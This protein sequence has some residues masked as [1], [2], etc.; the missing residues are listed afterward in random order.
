LKQ[1][2]RV[3]E[4][5]N[6]SGYVLQ[7]ESKVWC[8]PNYRSIDYIDGDEVERRLAKVIHEATDLSVLSAELR[9]QCI[10]WPSVYHLSSSRANILRPFDTVLH[11]GMQVLEIGAG[12][13]AVTRYL[14]ETGA[15]VTALERSIR[16]AAIARARTRDLKNINVVADNFDGFESPIKFDMVTLIGVLEYANLFVHDQNPTL[17]VLKRVRDLLKVDGILILAI[18][19]QLGLKYF[20]GAPEDHL[21]RLMYGI[22][23]QYKP[24]EPQTFGQV[25][26]TGKLR[27]A[28]FSNVEVAL[29]FPDYKHPASILTEAA[30]RMERFDAAAFAWQSVRRDSQLPK[31]CNFSPELAWG[32]IFANKLGA[33]L[34][35]S[36]LLAA[37]PART[38][39]FNRRMLAFHYATDRVAAYCKET[40]FQLD[41]GNAVEVSYKRLASAGLDNPPGARLLFNCPQRSEYSLGSPLSW[42]FMKLITAD[43]WVIEDVGEFIKKYIAILKHFCEEAG[44]E[45]LEARV[46]YVLPGEFFDLIPQNIIINAA[47][48]AVTIDKEWTM[49]GGVELGYLI[50]RGLLWMSNS[51]SRFGVQSNSLPVTRRQFLVSAMSSAGLTVT[52]S[53]IA[54][55]FQQEVRVQNQ[56]IGIDTSHTI[57]AVLAHEL[58]TQHAGAALS[59]LEREVQRLEQ[60]MDRGQGSIAEIH[61]VVAQRDQSLSA[62]EQEI[63]DLRKTIARKAENGKALN[64]RVGELEQMLQERSSYLEMVLKSHSWMLTMPF[65]AVSWQARR[66]VRLSVRVA[67]A[68]GRIGRELYNGISADGLLRGMA[69]TVERVKRRI[70]GAPEQGRPMT[71][72]QVDWFGRIRHDPL[73]S[74]LAVCFNGA[75]HLPE[76]LESLAQ[77]SYRNYEVII[78]DNGSSDGSADIIRRYQSKFQ[79]MQLILADRNLGFAEGNNVALEHARGELLLLVNVDTRVTEDWMRELVEALRCDGAAAIAASKILFWTRFHDIE[80]VTT[81]PVELDLQVLEASLEYKKYFVRTGI[82]TANKL[83]RTDENH[84]LVI[85]VPVQDNPVTLKLAGV[86][87]AKAEG[88]VRASRTN[89]QWV[90][91]SAEPAFVEL[92]VSINAVREAGFIINNAGSSRGP[93]K[94]PQDRGFGQYDIGQFDSKGYVPYCCGCSVMVRRAAIVGR[95]LFVPEF[96]AYY[97]DSELSGWVVQRGM[98]VL[99]V[100]R[101][102]LFHKHS[103][104]SSEGSQLWNYLVERSRR[105]FCFDNDIERLAKDLEL[106]RAQAKCLEGTELQTILSEYDCALLRRL[107]AN[108]RML[109]RR[110]GVAIYNSYWNTRGGGESHALSL[111]RDLRHMGEIFLVSEHDFDIVALQQY[112]GIDLYYCRKLVVPRITPDFTEKFTLFI[113]A[114]Y[115]SNLQSRAAYS[116]YIVSFPHRDVNP[117]ILNSY[118]F[119]FNSEYTRKWARL[120]WGTEVAGEVVYP[121]RMLSGSTALSSRTREKIILSVG[122]FFPSDHSKNQLEIAR[123]FRRVVATCK[124]ARGWKLVLA[125]SLNRSSPECVAYFNEVQACLAGLSAEVLPDLERAKVDY[126]FGTACVYVHATGLLCDKKLEPEKFEHFGITVAEAANAGCLP[127]VLDVGGPYELLSSLGIGYSFSSFESLVDTLVK[128]IE[129]DPESLESDRDIV[130]KKA[131]EFL[132]SEG[133]RELPSLQ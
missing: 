89:R 18:E 126:L 65:R 84:R 26:L 54:L 52:S 86:E 71:T 88:E 41:Q 127:V 19:N 24:T 110:D 77:Q 120:L 5:L 17:A 122:R 100:P 101:S 29:P 133:T 64:R 105:I 46:D 130:R 98:K 107:R 111:A 115:R 68:A 69:P 87:G 14:G 76:F 13:G 34:S 114:T 81:N 74:V 49:L 72:V 48:E 11:G 112:F 83:V 99:Y 78:V 82:A 119:L 3:T 75:R 1:D 79:A 131:Q 103:A 58:S 2:K 62:K 28:G 109:P 16:R 53:D 39:I 129:A 118:Y 61:L 56:V 121:V 22:E 60:E 66:L 42:Y 125:G 4:F 70:S 44:Q 51:V 116:W 95:P 63:R 9:G 38:E 37:S 50:F 94:M 40:V 117:E 43:G 132:E 67:F 35:N 92:D 30:L 31:Y 23:G 57:D 73:V 27:E 104:T 96:F 124:S 108:G 36:F 93:D 8:K 7:A 15:Q 113:N 128:I 106:S 59:A 20:A 47:G 45:L 10:D 102:I 123:A 85:S 97:E 90:E 55:Y 21:G 25:V 91:V 33:G 12:C 6:Q 32:A 80:L